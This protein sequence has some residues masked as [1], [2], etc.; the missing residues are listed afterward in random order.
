MKA[1]QGRKKTWLAFLFS[2]IFLIFVGV[3][4]GSALAVNVN[5]A[6]FQNSGVTVENGVLDLSEAA[7]KEDPFYYGIL[8]DVDFYWKRWIVTDN[9][10]QSPDSQIK[11]PSYWN[12]SGY[13]KEGYASYA[14]TITGVPAHGSIGLSFSEVPMA[15]RIF[16]KC[17][18]DATYTLL[19]TSGTMS[20]TAWNDPMP[21]FDNAFFRSSGGSIRVVYEIGY[22]PFGGMSNAP[23]VGN[24]ANRL[25]RDGTNI[26][27]GMG[28]GLIFSNLIFSFLLLL[29]HSKR[30]GSSGFFVVAAFMALF[31]LFSPDVTTWLL[32]FHWVVVPMFVSNMALLGIGLLTIGA[33]AFLVYRRHLVLWHYFDIPIVAGSSL[34]SVLLMIFLWNTPLA[35]I[36]I[37]P[38]VLFL[39]YLIFRIFSERDWEGRLFFYGLAFC[40]YA[41]LFSLVILDIGDTLIY[42][43]YGFYSIFLSVIIVVMNILYFFALYRVSRSAKLADTNKQKFLDAQSQSLV[44]Q[45]T[46]QFLFRSLSFLQ[47][48]YHASLALGDEA[49]GALSKT[50]RANIDAT[51]K[52]IVPFAEEL[53]AITH[54]VDFVSLKPDFAVDV[55]YDIS[56]ESFSVPPLAIQNYVES[57]IKRAKPKNK[58]AYVIVGCS[59]LEDQILL[60]IKD[61][62]NG[63]NPADSE[64]ETVQTLAI[65]EY[66]LQQALHAH[67]EIL[68]K[69]KGDTAIQILIP[70]PADGLK[71]EVAHE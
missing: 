39:S 9:D 68:S 29:S 33:F 18:N 37:F 23:Y 49:F 10:T 59:L 27:I 7:S 11:L 13:S 65:P 20:K 34:T 45:A 67:V 51:A 32:W 21:R 30:R 31:Y 12:E 35:F 48:R 4:V 19:G 1:P 47:D 69:P 40:L 5:Y 26:S 15:V 50:L 41:G 2:W 25:S 61:N 58:K 62:G 28:V 55:L 57:A 17:E 56:F 36:A 46:P 14:F 6:S 43:I 66:R 52:P 8:G 42:G 54:Y 16:Y 53:D 24:P 64:D 44:H 70:V 63:F 3:T 71:K 60:T 38:W 22:T